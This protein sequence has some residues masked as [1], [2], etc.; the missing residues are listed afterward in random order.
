[1]SLLTLCITGTLQDNTDRHQLVEQE[2]YCS[3]GSYC[4][5][6]NILRV[7]EKAYTTRYIP[8]P[9]RG[10]YICFFTGNKLWKLARCVM[11]R[12]GTST[13]IDSILISVGHCGYWVGEGLAFGVVAMVCAVLLAFCRHFGSP[14]HSLSFQLPHVFYSSLSNFSSSPSF[15]RVLQ[16]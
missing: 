10:I 16:A 2:L 8:W 3:L 12:V 5:L 1:M 13:F 7:K 14:S 9:L 6:K 4:Q 15:C 11:I